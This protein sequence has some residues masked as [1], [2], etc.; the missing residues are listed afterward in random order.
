MALMKLLLT[1]ALAAASANGADRLSIFGR[2]WSVPV[3]SDWKIDRE[4]STEVLHL[5]KNRGPLPGARR[6]IQFALTEV[7]DYSVLTL[8]SD[9]M[10]L[11]RSV[12]LVFA[13]RDEAHFDYAHISI[14]MATA[15]PVHN[16]IFH[17]YGG[18]RVRISAERGRAALGESGRWYHVKLTH[19]ATTGAVAVAVDGQAVPALEAVDRSLGSGKAGLGSFDETGAFKNVKISYT[20]AK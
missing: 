10:A 3:A 17:V 20:P 7:P 12:I 6:P 18:E 11:G 8:E 5:D 1:L 19:E 14:D 4:G 13:Y 9:V 16:G 2:T 15:Q